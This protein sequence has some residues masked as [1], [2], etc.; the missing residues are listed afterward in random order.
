MLGKH[1]IV[2][3]GTSGLG[4]EIT[5]RLIKRAHVTILARNKEKYKQINFKPF[6]K[7]VQMLNLSYY[8]IYSAGRYFKSISQHS[9]NEMLET[10]EVN[11]IGFNLLLH[12]LLPYLSK[13]AS[14]VGISSQA[15][16]IT[17]ANAA[18]Y[19]AS[20]A[21]FNAVLNALRLE[22]PSYHVMSV[23]PGPVRTP[24]HEKA[25]PSLAYAH[26]YDAMMLDPT[27]LAKD[28]ID[29][30]IKRKCEINQPKWMHSTLKFYQIFPRF[31]ESL[32]PFLFKTNSK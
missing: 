20:K 27:L 19:G 30:I 15:A 1:Y 24:F 32:F 17:Q 22:H 31:I 12:A 4:L 2:T 29:G 14:I 8:Q 21:A 6:E 5:K 3:G 28:I 7:R 16:F 10:Y 25:D 18:H 9:T 13:H 26:K 23:N 11:I